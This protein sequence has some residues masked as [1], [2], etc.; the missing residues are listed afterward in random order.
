MERQVAPDTEANVSHGGTRPLFTDPARPSRSICR[1]GTTGGCAAS[2]SAV[3]SGAEKD[4]GNYATAC[5]CL[6]EESGS[7]PPPHAGQPRPL[8][9]LR[10]S[11]KVTT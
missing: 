8:T 7:T 5:A 3:T 10:G 6:P 9:P 1:E 2:V 11:G 4:V